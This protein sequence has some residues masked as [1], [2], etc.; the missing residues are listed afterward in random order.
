MARVERVF[1]STKSE[2]CLSVTQQLDRGQL[3]LVYNL[4][5]LHFRLA[6]GKNRTTMN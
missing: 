3:S 4:T 2:F 1:M 6:K 5:L